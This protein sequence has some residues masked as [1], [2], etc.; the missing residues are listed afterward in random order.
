MGRSRVVGID[1]GL[2][3]VGLAVADPLGVFAQPIGAFSPESAIAELE[4]LHGRDGIGTVVLGWPLK[5][6][7]TE[8]E[9]IGDV[10]TFE[11]RLQKSFPDVEIVRWDER[12]SSKEAEETILASGARKKKRRQKG[13]IDAVAAAIILQSYLDQ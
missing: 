2:A 10:K 1:F 7:G 13:N 5:L 11:R 12:F 6:D 3:R 9:I 8:S 4:Q